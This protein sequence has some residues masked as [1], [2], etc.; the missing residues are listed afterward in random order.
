MEKEPP[1]FR[2]FRQCA[3]HL[4]V[5]FGHVASRGQRPCEG[6]VSEDI[7]ARSKFRSCEAERRLRI[8][9]PRREKESQCAGIPGRAVLAK[10][11]LDS[12]RFIFAFHCAQR[13][14][15]RPLIF[16]ERI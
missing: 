16:G 10:L 1:V 7:T 3:L 13:L 4:A 14:G 15:E 9:V 2:A 12:R 5:R 6:I 8:L 11:R